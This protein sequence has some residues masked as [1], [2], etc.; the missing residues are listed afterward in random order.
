[1]A[2]AEIKPVKVDGLDRAFGRTKG[3]LPPMDEIPDEFKKHRSNKWVGVVETWFFRG[4]KKC[5]W[6]PKEGIDTQEALAHVQAITASFE[7]S[8]EHKT[9]G[10]AYL[11]SCFFDDVKYEAAK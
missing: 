5:V 8:H 2:V 11:L 7:P 4:I 6:K 3:L 9:A 10:C 1:M